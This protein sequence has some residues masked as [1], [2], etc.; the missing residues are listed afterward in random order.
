MV[1]ERRG[2]WFDP[3]LA[4]ILLAIGP[5]DR[6]WSDL[7]SDDVATLVRE[8]E[9]AD[10]VLVLDDGGARPHLRGLRRRHRREVALH[11]AP[12][13]RSGDL[14]RPD[15]ERARLAPSDLRDLYRAG[16]LHDIGKLGIPNTILDKPGKLDDEE[17]AR[18]R[19]HPAFT[20]SILAGIPAFAGFATI[21]A[22]HHER[23]DG[24][25]YHRGIPAGDL[26]L[27]AR[28][29]AAAD[30]FEAMTADRPYRGPMAP[31]EALA[32]ARSD[33]GALDPRCV[34]A[35]AGAVEKAAERPA[36]EK[37]GSG[38]TRAGLTPAVRV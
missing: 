14:R 4:D 25:G 15:R 26:P 17:F 27:A 33:A 38:A 29:L 13:S 36:A 10:R 22:A 19:L 6:L 23:L 1:R 12:F 35:L 28:I 3:E 5:A 37:R 34:E 30:V 8:L 20:E 18:I 24:R 7:A 32:I 21:A 9:P 2:R 16:L 11:G 31:E